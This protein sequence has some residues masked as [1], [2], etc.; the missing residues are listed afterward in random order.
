M[1]ISRRR[2]GWPVH[3]VGAAVPAVLGLVYV[4][5]GPLAG[6]WSAGPGNAPATAS[7]SAP[8]KDAWQPHQ[9][10]SSQKRGQ[11]IGMATAGVDTRT[12]QRDGGRIAYEIHGEGPLIVCIPGMGELRSSYRYNVGSLRAAGLRVA[13][14][15]LRGHGD[16]ATTFGSFDDVAAATDALALIE[17]LGGPALVVGNSMGAGAA[18]WAAAERPDLVAAIALLGPFVRQA[19]IN[20][21]MAW[22]FKIAMSGP[23]A[24]MVW[25]AYLPALYPGSK[26]ADF[27]EH[28]AAIRASMRR[29]GYAQAFTATTRSSH[30]PAEARLSEVKVPALVVMGTAD[31]DF[32]DP[33]AEAGWIVAAL[34]DADQLLVQ[35]AGHYPQAED[36]DAVNPVLVNFARAVLGPQGPSTEQTHG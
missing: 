31:P 11:E 17:E 23:W 35:G 9:Q 14:M 33:T 15:D 13:A 36:P 22:A 27:A 12:L 30:A 7:A 21:L 19:P 34:A 32:K 4:R 2:N 29:R 10:V 6:A 8:P 24:P 5:A 3:A 16:S 18:V 20:P 26:P 1:T 25:N 28:R